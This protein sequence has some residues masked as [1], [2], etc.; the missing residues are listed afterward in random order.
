MSIQPI[1][2]AEYDL[3]DDFVARTEN[4]TI[5][6]TAWWHRA[7]GAK[8]V[9]YARKNEEG[10]IESGLA[11]NITKVQG[12]EGIRRGP[13]SPVNGPVFAF[14]KSGNRLSQNSCLRQELTEIVAALPRLSFVELIFSPEIID[15]MPFLW[16]GFEPELL[17]TYVIPRSESGRWRDNISARHRGC[18]KLARKEML[19]FGCKIEVDPPFAEVQALLRET[20]KAKGFVLPERA[21]EWWEEVLKRNAGRAY[22]VRDQQ[23]RVLCA[24][25]M[26]WDS[27]S[28]YFVLAGMTA[29]ARRKT[30]L[31]F[32]L[33]ERMISDAHEMGLDFDFEGSVLPGVDRFFRGWGGELRTMIRVLKVPSPLT[34]MVWKGI[35]LKV[36][37]E[38]SQIVFTRR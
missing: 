24:T 10:E 29:E 14:C 28:S 30:H 34:Y 21:D 12:L 19:R 23:S 32:L 22:V 36:D 8:L 38:Q 11:A 31:N 9:V 33:V 27:S 5:F 1:G 6:Q 18:L 16:D 3:W 4:G 15:V 35:F 17:Y 26:V 25:I 37:L 13:V 7:W 2:E 20:A